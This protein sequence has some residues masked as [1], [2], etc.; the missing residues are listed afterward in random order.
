MKDERMAVTQGA[1][2]VARPTLATVMAQHGGTIFDTNRNMTWIA[3]GEGNRLHIADEGLLGR[4]KPQ[5]SPRYL[6]E[7]VQLGPRIPTVS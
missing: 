2:A 6:S 3:R 1:P 5:P 7:T 4:R